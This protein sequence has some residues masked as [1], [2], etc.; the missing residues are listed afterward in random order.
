MQPTPSSVDFALLS[1][2]DAQA[3]LFALAAPLTA[4]TADLRAAAGR[5]AA[6]AVA[7]R[8]DHPFADLSAMDGYAI[9]FADMPGPWRVVQEIAAGSLPKAPIGPGEAARIF[10]GAPLPQ[11]ADAILIQEEARREDDRLLLAGEGPRAAGAFVRPKAMN[12]RAGAVLIEAG[13]RLTSARIGL[14]ALAGQAMLPVRRRPRIALVST[15]DELA[16]PGVPLR[17]GQIHASNG[18]MLTALLS[19]LPAEVSDLGIM[20]DDEAALRDAFAR[21][22]RDADIL[23]TSGGA[24]V[25]AHDLVRPALLAAG[26]EIDFWRV[27]MKPGKPLMAGRIGDCV[28]LGLPGNP[29]SAYVTA[30]LFLRPLIATLGGAA[31]PLPRPVPLPLGSALPANGPRFDFVRAAVRDG[32][33][34]PLENQDSSALAAL[35]EA[36]AL[37]LRPPH[38]PAVSEGE[39]VELHLLT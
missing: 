13:A 38:A 6:E 30:W 39:T 5:W 22:A 24:S 20:P 16:E 10:T 26:A 9:R 11:G 35:A 15:G 3:R 21:A 1:L 28:V 34:F 2:A 33:A 36:D 12:F 32:G 19:D 14:A 23:V 29:V 37:V 31:D 18:A 27:A 7:A 8:H 4:E 25:G 17:P